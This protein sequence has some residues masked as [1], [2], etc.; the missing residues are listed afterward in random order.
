VET[1]PPLWATCLTILSL[2]TQ[3][4]IAFAF[5]IKYFNKTKKK[6]EYQE[7]KIITPPQDFLK[8]L[9]NIMKDKKFLL[10]Y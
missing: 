1:L 7:T 6:T 10:H 2:T 5:M 8:M 3:L 9:N 4:N